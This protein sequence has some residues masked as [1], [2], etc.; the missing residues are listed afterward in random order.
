MIVIWRMPSK[1]VMSAIALIRTTAFPNSRKAK[2]EVPVLSWSLHLVLTQTGGYNMSKKTNFWDSGDFP[3]KDCYVHQ[4]LARGDVPNDD[5]PY[6]WDSTSKA[7]EDSK[8]SNGKSRG[9][10]SARSA[11]SGK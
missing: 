1:T 4:R 10:S 3:L 5:Y 6:S 9:N 8:S 7:N 2:K 11:K